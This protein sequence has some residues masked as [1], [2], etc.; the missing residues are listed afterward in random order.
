MTDEIELCGRC[1]PCERLR[2]LLNKKAHAER[3]REEGCGFIRIPVHRGTGTP[4]TVEIAA[5]DEEGLAEAIE[6]IDKD[7]EINRQKIATFGHATK[8]KRRSGRSKW[9]ADYYRRKRQGPAIFEQ[10]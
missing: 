9:M 4:E 3:I 5:S 8:R 6:V 7:I 1:R 10:S 2:H